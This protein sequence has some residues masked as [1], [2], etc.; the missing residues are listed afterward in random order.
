MDGRWTGETGIGR[1]TKELS[2]RLTN[3]DLI[4]N[5]PKPLSIANLIWQPLKLRNTRQYKAYFSPGFNPVFFTKTPYITTIC[6]LISLKHPGKY[7]AIKKAFFNSFI[8]PSIKNAH[9]VFTISEYS[10]NSIIEW[11]NIPPEKIINISCGIS[12]IFIQNQKK[13]N[14]GFPYILNVGNNKPHKNILRLVKA[15]YK[16]KICSSTKLILTSKPSSEVKRFITKNYLHN[17]IIFKERLTEENLAALYKGAKALIFPSLH[18]GF[19]L[20]ILEAMASGTPVLTSNQTSCPEIAGNAAFMVDP[21]DTN[22]IATGISR[23]VNDHKLR[24]DL[25]RKGYERVK[26]YTWDKTAK[27]VSNAL[28]EAISPSH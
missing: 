1:I 6:D 27:I 23:I 8:K 2:A 13:A 4:N 11:T 17:R 25:R 14:L 28:N 16:A 24:D 18:E 7:G 12:D 15:F 22:E 19:G 3:I 21:Y 5:G 20:P 26:L 10:K 9:Q